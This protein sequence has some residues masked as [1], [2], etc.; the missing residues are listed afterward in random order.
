MSAVQSPVALILHAV[1]CMYTFLSFHALYT[2]GGHLD[3]NIK[4][5]CDYINSIS[6]WDI[7]TSGE[8]YTTSRD[9]QSLSGPHSP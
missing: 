2:E 9:F 6:H 1:P 4:R 7:R 3:P 5:R 8:V